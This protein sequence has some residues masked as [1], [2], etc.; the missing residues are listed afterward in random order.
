[1]TEEVTTRLPVTASESGKNAYYLP[2]CN[3]VDHVPAYCSCLDKIKQIKAAGRSAFHECSTAARQGRCKAADMRQEEELKGEALYFVPRAGLT[4][5][6]H[7]G[8]PVPSW[9][10]RMPTPKPKRRDLST[11]VGGSFADAINEAM[12][13][14]PVAPRPTMPAPTMVAGETPMQFAR[15]LA[16]TC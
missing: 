3:V 11:N 13:S 1:M 7:G 15:R 16:V 14:L 8:A 4:Q 5:A 6:E 9:S 2:N 10:A 12:K